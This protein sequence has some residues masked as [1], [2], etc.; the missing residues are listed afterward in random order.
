MTSTTSSTAG[1]IPPRMR[2][3]ACGHVGPVGLFW[4]RFGYIRQAG[5]GCKACDTTIAWLFKE[6]NIRR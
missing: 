4:R 5:A 2:C 6:W 1:I 3:P